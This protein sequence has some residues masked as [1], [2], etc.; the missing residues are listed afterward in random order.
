MH[1]V[2]PSARISFLNPR[3]QQVDHPMAFGKPDAGVSRAGA[4]DL[5]PATGRTRSLSPLHLVD[6][7]FECG[8]A[9]LP[10][11]TLIAF[12]VGLIPFAASRSAA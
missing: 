11:V 1:T 5:L 9:A 4:A 10:I 7:M 2:R 6:I 8:A 3:R 12:L